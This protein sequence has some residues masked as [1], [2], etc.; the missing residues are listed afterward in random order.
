[1]QEKKP[2]HFARRLVAASMAMVMAAGILTGCSQQSII[3]TLDQ[4][5]PA[6]QV[7][8]TISE[9]SKWI[10]STIDGSI[11]ADTPTNLKDDF[12]TAVNRDW[13]L[14]PLPDGVA[15]VQGYD[16][17]DDKFNAN[18]AALL[19]M[20][21]EDTT[22]LDPEV[23]SAE[24]LIHIQTLVH[25]LVDTAADEATRNAAGAE[26]LRP[27]IEKIN[28]ISTL[29]ELTAYQADISGGNPF[30]LQLMYFSV[31]APFSADAADNYTVI[32][33]PRTLLALNAEAE[34]RDI[35]S[36]GLAT[37]KYNTDLFQYELQQ[38]GYT[39]D[40]VND[41][42]TA[43]YRFEIKLARLLPTE[44]AVQKIEYFVENNNVY[45]R[46]GLEELAGNY[47]IT[48]ILDAYGVGSSETFTVPDT[49]QLKELGR[50]YTEENLEDMKAYFIVQTVLN[51]VDLLDET[52]AAMEA[53]FQYQI[54]ENKKSADA[55]E[56]DENDEDS[57]DGTEDEPATI[58]LPDT[59]NPLAKYYTNYVAKYM[60]DAYQQM[61][62]A[63]YCTAAEK[64]D[65]RKMAEKIIAA[66]SDAV[67]E[68]DWMSDETKAK[69][70]D[71]LSAMG[72]H[73]LYPDNLI[74]Y[75]ALS[76]DG[77]ENLVDMVAA[78]NSFEASQYAAKVN[79]PVNRSEWNLVTIPSLIVNAM[80]NMEDNSINICAGFLA[81]DSIYSEKNTYEHNLA[82]L[83]TVL[84]H[85][86]THGFDTTGYKFDKNGRYNSW[87][88]DEDK[89]AYDKRA[90][91]LIKY[92]SSLSPVSRGTFMNGSSVSGEAIADLGGMK[93]VLRV[94]A[95]T[96]DFDYDVF[97]RS[98]AEMW[99]THRTL[100]VET[101]YSSDSHPTSMLRTNVVLE[102]FDEFQKTYD[103]QPGDGM[104]LP[105]DKRITVW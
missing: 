102:Q 99:R 53:D 68:S 70:Q 88:T 98:Y 66:F 73:I 49:L 71:K 20:S 65:I 4:Y 67:A 78:L 64:R 84:G 80:Y 104:Y 25:Q 40:E 38:L 29:D 3:D 60:Y 24:K 28:S 32:F 31:E 94:A 100:M 37:Y 77:C 15:M 17:I 85:E 51:A 105:A 43:C 5:M 83:G 7:N 9:D 47:P 33:N 27:Y 44:S 58:E 75:T 62:I 101:M 13:L 63:H 93:C 54:S 12:Y 8:E 48:T 55:D 11:N 10:N 42:L 46:A 56:D 92:Y 23:M 52:T 59:D 2:K 97:F 86:I 79:Q 19:D 30:C 45:D 69:A 103:I 1:M 39:E 57:T 6:V 95:E 34:Y 26:P 22:G 74:D 81:T 72:L 41:L 91:A 87:W 21:A 82:C 76:F 61:Y 89:Y 14:K 90:D 36:T 96:P 16:E 18:Q 35:G 50:L